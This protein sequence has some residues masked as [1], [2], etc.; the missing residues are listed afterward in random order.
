MS[1]FYCLPKYTTTTSEVSK[2]SQLVLTLVLL[3]LE[4]ET[5]HGF[6]HLDHGICFIQ[7]VFG[8]GGFSADGA[9]EHTSVLYIKIR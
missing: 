5:L 6:E 2:S 9:S 1:H 8:L 4:T 7:E 3:G